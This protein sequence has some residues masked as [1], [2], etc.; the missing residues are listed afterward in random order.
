MLRRWLALIASTALL[1]A[2]ANHVRYTSDAFERPA[3]EIVYSEA[4]VE[5]QTPILKRPDVELA[6][7]ADE[8]VIVRK[9]RSHVRFD[10]Y[11]PYR[12]GYEMWEVPV[13]A[14]CLPTLLVLRVVDT[15]GFGFVP[16]TKLD[17]F[18]S[19]TFSALNPLLNLESESR[20][21]RNEVSRETE[22]LD[23]EVQR[24]LRPLADAKVDLA[25][26]ARAPQRFKS[27]ARGRVQVELLSLAPE[28][29]PGR[30]RVLRVS[31]EGEGKREPRVFELPLSPA[32]SSQ[33]ARAVEVRR[34]ARAP[35]TSPEAIG[36]SLAELDA[37]GFSEAALS[38][39]RELRIREDANL[40]WLARLDS[41][42]RP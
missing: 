24:S 1:P 26:D 7:A 36:R 41:A 21:R 15:V 39:E 10:E 34:R 6:L 37:L 35:G 11:T 17:D 25:L 16:E 31:I 38:L 8:T 19:F 18:S 3:R 27:D 12:S 40:A 33:L 2:C 30:P 13:G 22:E 23:R 4:V 9:L 14:V 29:L 42:L 32:L 5:P 28:T 20:L